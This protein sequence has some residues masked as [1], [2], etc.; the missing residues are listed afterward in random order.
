MCEIEGGGF[1]ETSWAG[2]ALDQRL[3]FLSEVFG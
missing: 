2:P 3:V 1:G